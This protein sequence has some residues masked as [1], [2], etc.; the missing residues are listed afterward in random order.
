MP[1]KL[2]PATIADAQALTD[3][4]HRAKASWG[5]P[6][7]KMEEFR[8]QWRISE[9]TIRSLAVTVAER[10]GHPVAFSGLS[11]QDEET[12]LID[13]LFVAPEAQCQGIG[14]LLLTRA[15]DVARSRKLTRLFLESDTNAAPFYEKRGFRTM[16]TR[17][18]EMQPEGEIPMMEKVLQPGVHKVSSIDIDLSPA[19]WAFE[20]ANEA[21][22]AAH[23]EE[24][25]KRIALLWNGRTLK[26][27]DFRFQDGAFK[28]TCCECSYAAFLTWKEWGAP[29]ASTYNL[30]G[31]AV[32]RSADGALLYGV[33]SARTA[34]A[35]QIYPPGGNLDPTD[36]TPDGKV[37]VIG[38][39]YRELAEETGLSERDVRPGD[40]LIAFDGPRIALAQVFDIDRKA[41][42]LRQN[43]LR[44]SEASEEQ[45]LADIRIVRGQED[46]TDPAITHYARA[47]G[48]YLMPSG[49][50]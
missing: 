42:A 36:L 26:L 33:M 12:L 43:I 11:P 7:E 39:I 19:A 32:L 48:A 47:I 46:L 50:V 13:F 21:A 3:V 44:F 9:A 27:T 23:F 6:Q 14:D 2:R 4:M 10:G 30:F 37:D 28:G 34:T 31:S 22:I 5:Y 38:A 24:A 18:S 40:L 20:T 41:D 25:R 17:P 35:G 15:E 49:P 29:D 45:E 1:L 8:A 16:A